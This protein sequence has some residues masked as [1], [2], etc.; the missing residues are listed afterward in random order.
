MTP[1][2]LRQIGEALDSERW[3]TAMARRRGV[4]VRTIQ[5]WDAEQRAVPDLRV[6]LAADIDARIA[7]LRDLKRKLR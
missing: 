5:R 6:E 3:Q 1:E 2:L 4:A 7:E